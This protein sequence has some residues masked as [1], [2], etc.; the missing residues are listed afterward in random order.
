M[1]N[2]GEILPLVGSN[3][4]GLVV[5]ELWLNESE[6]PVADSRASMSV[7]QYVQY[8]LDN[9]QS[10]DEIIA[11]DQLIRLRPSTNNFTKV[12]FFAVDKM[13]NNIVIEFL[14]GKMVYHSKETMPIKVM[15]NDTYER[16]INYVQNGIKWSGTNHIKAS[17]DR[18]YTATTLIFQV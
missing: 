1:S 4:A 10:I 8:I 2:T 15:T 18:F 12:H 5:N 9:F 14:H 6:Y 17:L 3:E 7:D 13:G 11:S 16:S